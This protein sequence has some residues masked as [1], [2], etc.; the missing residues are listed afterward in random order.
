MPPQFSWARVW[1]N[2]RPSLLKLARQPVIWLCG[3]GLLALAALSLW[4]GG[5]SPAASSVPLPGG[6]A[7]QPDFF[8]MLSLVAS[9][10]FKL[11]FVIALI[12]GGMYLLR[13]WPGGWF[14]ASQKRVSLLET[15]RLSPRQALHL[16][17]VGNRTLLV[18][19]TD[20]AVTLLAEV[21]PLV[22]GEA[23][24]AQAKPVSQA[25]SYALDQAL[26]QPDVAALAPHGKSQI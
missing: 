15:T 21:A 8:G 18:G 19:A 23:A 9:V 4:A 14:T 17:Q 6:Q 16:V 24:P 11:A 12:Y 20:Q 25:F 1:A 10:T 22:E 26:D 13:R 2:L 3:L 5:A 7:P